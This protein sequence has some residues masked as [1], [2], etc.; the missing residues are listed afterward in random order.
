MFIERCNERLFLRLIKCP[1]QYTAVSGSDCSRHALKRTIVCRWKTE[2]E[3]RGTME[4]RRAGQPPTYL[5]TFGSV[6]TMLLERPNSLQ[7]WPVSR[8]RA[9]E[10]VTQRRPDCVAEVPVHGWCRYPGITGARAVDCH[11]VEKAGVTNLESVDTAT[12]SLQTQRQ[13]CTIGS[14]APDKAFQQAS[15]C[16]KLFANP[17][18]RNQA[19]VR[20]ARTR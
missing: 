3:K 7:L 15:T 16:L 1:C 11:V 19:A 13:P 2:E 10:S 14:I 8:Q 6:S 9:L 20:R 12:R 18:L 5:S 17:P 4:V